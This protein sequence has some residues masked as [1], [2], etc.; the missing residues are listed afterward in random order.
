M[1][2]PEPNFTT[3]IGPYLFNNEVKKDNGLNSFNVNLE[4]DEDLIPIYFKQK[5]LLE[6]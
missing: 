4:T 1:K 2:I 3:L 6:N 5:H